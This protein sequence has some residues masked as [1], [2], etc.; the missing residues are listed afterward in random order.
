MKDTH[1]QKN[2]P[3]DEEIKLQQWLTVHP[4]TFLFQEIEIR[5]SKTSFRFAQNPQSEAPLIKPPRASS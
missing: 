5:H 1:E 3:G 4:R 2:S